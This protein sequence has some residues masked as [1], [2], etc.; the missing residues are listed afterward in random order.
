MGTRTVKT[1][2]E[3]LQCK[4][5]SGKKRIRAAAT[6]ETGLFFR[7]AL[8]CGQKISIFGV[9][10][11]IGWRY[12]PIAIYRKPLYWWPK[13]GCKTPGKDENNAEIQRKCKENANKYQKSVT[14]HIPVRLL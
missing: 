1:G 14:N 9:D 10:I 13:R 4:H 3:H 11:Y 12:N 5:V 2:K 7:L 8:T 6:A